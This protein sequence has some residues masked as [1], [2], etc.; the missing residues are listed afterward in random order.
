TLSQRSLRSTFTFPEPHYYWCEVYIIGKK[1]GKIVARSLIS[2]LSEAPALFLGRPEK[3]FPAP[4][5]YRARSASRS[6]FSRKFCEGDFCFPFFWSAKLGWFGRW[7]SWA[8]GCCLEKNS[9]GRCRR[10]DVP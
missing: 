7:V 10:P 4:F 8:G 5:T 2:L 3:Q 6:S 9:T 1:E